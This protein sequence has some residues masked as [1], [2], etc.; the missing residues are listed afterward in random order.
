MNRRQP[1]ESSHGVRRARVVALVVALPLV[2]CACGAGDAARNAASDAAGSA[3]SSVRQAAT[4]KV[5][6]QVCQATTGSGPLADV[7]LNQSERAT[8]G[9][10]AKLA[11]AS[12]VPQRYVEPLQKIAASRDDQDVADAIKSLRTACADQPSSSAS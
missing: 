10:L 7:R 6:Q 8:V 5:V 9:A 1:S 12:G 11:S 2:L 4:D 3:S